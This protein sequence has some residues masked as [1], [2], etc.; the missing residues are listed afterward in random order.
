MAWCQL[1]KE[2]TSVL[3]FLEGSILRM[4]EEYPSS[5]NGLSRTQ[6]DILEIVSNGVQQLGKVFVEQ[7][8]REERVFLGDIVFADIITE[9]MS[10]KMP[11]LRVEDSERCELPF[12]PDKTVMLTNLARDVLHAQMSWLSEHSIDKWLG[13]VHLSVNN[14]WLWNS[15]RNKIERG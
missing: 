5:H 8:K 10:Q 11:L 14:M 9:L 1:L 7:Q 6:N 3:P 4:L 15:D 12:S 2:D 13:G